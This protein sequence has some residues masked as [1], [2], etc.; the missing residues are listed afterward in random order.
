MCVSNPIN[1]ILERTLPII[2]PESATFF[3]IH[4][5]NFQCLATELFTI[6]K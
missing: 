6:N 2:Y 1:R 4:K 5:I 3:T